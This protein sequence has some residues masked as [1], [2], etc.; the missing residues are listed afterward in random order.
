MYEVTQANGKWEAL[1]GEF[2][3]PQLSLKCN[4]KLVEYPFM[5]YHTAEN[6]L[7]NEV[8]ALLELILKTGFSK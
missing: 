3:G 2:T 4:T 6:I 5:V 7:F 8:N 1:I